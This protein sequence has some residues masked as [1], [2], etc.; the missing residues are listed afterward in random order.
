[1]R[2]GTA[3]LAGPL[4]LANDLNVVAGTFD[5]DANPVD[6]GGA[7]TVVGTL[8]ADGTVLHVARNVTA[9]GSFQ[10]GTGALVLDGAVAQ[11]LDLGASALN[12]LTVENAAGA[13][14]AA[15]LVVGGTLDLATGTLTIGAHRLT[16]AMP[17]EG[18]PGNLVAGSSSSLTVAGVSAGIV[19]PVSVTDLAEL[20]VTNPAGTALGGPLTLHV[21]LVLAGGNVV[22][23]PHLLAI[24]AGGTV[25]RSSGHVIGR[26]QKTIPTGGPMSVT[27]EIGDAL[28]YTP[29][30]ASWET[31]TVTGTMAASTSAGDDVAGLTAVGLVPAA[32]VNRTWTIGS[33][34]LVVGP[35]T[36]LVT[37]LPT[38]L[39]PAANPAALLAAISAGGTSSLP[40]VTARG[41]ASVTLVL[42]GAPNGVL[43]LA[44]PGA[45][46]DVRLTGPATGFVDQAY[47]YLVTVTNAGPFDASSVV[48]EIRLQPG[49]T[50]VA[51]TPT[52]G[53]CLLSAAV[54][55]CDLGPVA[56]GAS[57]EVNI[58][59]S[60]TSPGVHRLAAEVRVG[61]TA[62]DPA[63]PN[64]AATLDVTIGQ[65]TPT[66]TPSAQASRGTG[67]LP[68]TS[69]PPG[70]LLS[71]IGLVA[72]ALV[73][74]LLI[75]F[76][77]RLRSST[78]R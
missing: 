39:D 20:A 7:L 53:S 9:S 46:L 36:L 59:V 55:T 65:P 56:S 28:G 1:V 23:G 52:Q 40:T 42:G 35:T 17:I 54:L 31:V 22:A 69:T 25:A 73:A 24:T 45:D 72:L 47:P 43:A 18:I 33:S 3:T 27:F 51:S 32:S 57:A 74:L 11:Q 4:T 67:R 49:A 10:A 13:T 19:V 16:I 60:F 50:W 26:L 58:V 21:G 64:D 38:D 66:P 77:S 76:G 70:W 8:I 2:G 78:R 48:I 71:M 15:D 61:A 12:D 5:L 62:I 63:P 37:Y 34:G 6:V 68:D 14:L 75:A 41:E 30:L 44:M 29:L